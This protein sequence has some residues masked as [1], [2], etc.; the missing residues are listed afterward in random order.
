[1]F[2]GGGN[3]RGFGGQGA[4]VFS[5]GGGSFGQ[6]Q[7]TRR[8]TAT[9]ETPTSPIVAL[10]PIIILFAFALISIL[11]SLFSTHTP[12]PAYSFTPSTD[13]TI[14][15]NTFSYG[16]P[17]YVNK[18]NWDESGVWASV[19]EDRRGTADQAKYSSKLRAFERGIESVYVRKLQNE[20]QHFND[21]RQQRIQ[22]EAGFFGIGANIEKI[23]QLRREKH[24]SCEQLKGWGMNMQQQGYY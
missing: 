20:C 22:N 16:I 5:F 6:P 9:P 15:R 1:M 19:P 7:Y 24:E 8:R 11:P 12:D 10:L 4:N 3:A 21:V 14:G 2:F 17:Y 13:Y 18:P 23:Q